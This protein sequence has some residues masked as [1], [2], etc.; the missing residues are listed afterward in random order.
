M[1]E[2]RYYLLDGVRERMNFPTLKHRVIRQEQIRG[3]HSVLIE[4]AGSGYAL[5]KCLLSE[6][7][8]AVV[9]ITPK[10]DKEVR[11]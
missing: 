8:L 5:L 11:L 1:R 10:L 4:K 9:P 3:A 6:T 2:N 7:N